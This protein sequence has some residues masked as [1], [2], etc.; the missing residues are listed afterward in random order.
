MVG[1]VVAPS[2]IV[3]DAVAVVGV[4]VV[5]DVACVVSRVTATMLG[6]GV[7]ASTCFIVS[8][9]SAVDHLRAWR[10][11]QIAKEKRKA[12]RTKEQL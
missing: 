10:Y 8:I 4:V 1:V 3:V 7:V 2:G 9:R 11:L 6:S 5:V 12:Q